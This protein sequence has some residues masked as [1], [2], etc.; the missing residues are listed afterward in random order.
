M[1]P[2]F[3][4]PHFFPAF[5]LSLPSNLFLSWSIIYFSPFPPSVS[6][7]P[8]PPDFTL[9][10]S[11]YQSVCFCL[12][13]SFHCSL[14]RHHCCS[15]Q[16]ICIILPEGA[17]KTPWLFG[18]EQRTLKVL[19][20]PQNGFSGFFFFNLTRKWEPKKSSHCLCLFFSVFASLSL[21]LDSLLLSLLLIHIRLCYVLSNHFMCPLILIRV[22][23]G[24]NLSQH[25]WGGGLSTPW[26][27][28]H[29]ITR[30]TH[31]E[32]NLGAN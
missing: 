4:V 27:N 6:L 17:Y 14:K 9:L 1:L 22:V 26:E 11:P 20:G 23:E 19:E 3:S 10:S 30:L 29:S 31:I 7:S 25:A 13:P 2:V 24:W 21:S 28:C 12:K 16:I 32:K 15:C 5:C 18:K 8:A